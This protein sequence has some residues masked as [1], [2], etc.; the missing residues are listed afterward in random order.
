M[1]WRKPGTKA[2]CAQGALAFGPCG[3]SER[4]FCKFPTTHRLCLHISIPACQPKHLR[5]VNPVDSLLPHSPSPALA[6][7]T[8]EVVRALGLVGSEACPEYLNAL[9]PASLAR[10]V[11]QLRKYMADA[12]TAVRE[13]VADAFGALAEG[14]YASSTGLLPGAANANPLLRAALA[15]L[16]ETKREA[17]ATA[18]MALSKVNC[19]PIDNV[20][21]TPAA[22]FWAPVLHGKCLDNYNQ[23][24]NR[25]AF[26]D[27]SAVFS[28][29]GYYSA[30]ISKRPG[31][32]ACLK[33]SSASDTTTAD[34]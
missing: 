34:P 7:R 5:C 31:C 25:N 26:F 2:Q 6:R 32:L 13:A 12:D 1:L 19:S 22:A 15:A 17:Q 30:S 20:P 3:G 21:R 29:A 10:I 11:A 9:Q 23:C 24:T 28:S 14:M 8:Q 4:C 16:A 18:C 27:D 33:R